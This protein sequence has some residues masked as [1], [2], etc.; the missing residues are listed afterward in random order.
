MNEELLVKS[1]K[2]RAESGG[3]GRPGCSAFLL[4]VPGSLL[5]IGHCEGHAGIVCAAVVL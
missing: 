4:I 2:L 1:G 3:L 5:A